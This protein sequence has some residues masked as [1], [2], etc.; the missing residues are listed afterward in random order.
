MKATYKNL[1][2]IWINFR[3]FALLLFYF[4]DID[5]AV[6]PI[7]LH[8]LPTREDKKKPSN[9]RFSVIA[10]PSILRMYFGLYSYGIACTCVRVARTLGGWKGRRG[11]NPSAT[12]EI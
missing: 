11:L 5:I 1:S 12:S 7:E 6:Y 3:R 9:D 10:S 2:E 8:L 4:I